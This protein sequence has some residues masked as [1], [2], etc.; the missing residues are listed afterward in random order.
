MELLRKQI[1]FY[2]SFLFILPL[3]FGCNTSQAKYSVLFTSD[4]AYGKDKSY[5][6]SYS[7]EGKVVDK[8]EIVGALHYNIIENDDEL[9]FNNGKNLISIIG[10]DKKSTKL[11]NE[12]LGY[13][14]KNSYFFYKGSPVYVYN[15]GFDKENNYE[16]LIQF[17]KTNMI[18]FNGFVESFWKDENYFYALVSSY[19]KKAK[20]DLYMI[21]INLDTKKIEKEEKISLK[22]E[23]NSVLFG[24]KTKI[25][26]NKI[27]VIKD[28]LSSDT[29][30]PEDRKIYSVSLNDFSVSEST[31]EG[32]SIS[33]NIVNDSFFSFNDSVY[34][35]AENQIYQF[36]N[37]DMNIVKKTSMKLPKEFGESILINIKDNH[38][39]VLE[40]GTEIYLSEIDINKEMISNPIR[41]E[42]PNY[43]KNM[44]ASSFIII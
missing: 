44:E 23:D 24:I 41:I 34:F 26:N 4:L 14:E 27:Y 33:E 7:E 31:I 42:T 2:L 21:K 37:E 16:S 30:K 35:I 22:K 32:M 1:K 40:T 10:K 17:D 15:V 25:I 6:I 39:Y 29:N 12:P 18:W 38:I 11:G 3:L 28:I 13:L 9:V 20:N 43:T 19:N 5:L 36:Q 8:N